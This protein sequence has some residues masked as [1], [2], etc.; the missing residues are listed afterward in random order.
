MNLWPLLAAALCTPAT[1]AQT[2]AP[3]LRSAPSAPVLGTG[4]LIAPL[5]TSSM[6]SAK[7]SPLPAAPYLRSLSRAPSLDLTP[8]A[9]A[10]APVPSA[11]SPTAAKVGEISAQTRDILDKTGDLSKASAAD[12]REAGESLDAVL[13]GE[14][15]ALTAAADSSGGLF[16]ALR[17]LADVRGTLE[18]LVSDLT[19]RQATIEEASFSVFNGRGRISGLALR[20]PAAPGA[21]PALRAYSLDFDVEVRS[22]LGGPVHFRSIEIAGLDLTVGESQRIEQ[23]TKAAARQS[24][25][26][27]ARIDRL[28]LRQ[29][30]LHLGGP[31]LKG[32]APTFYLR[33]MEWG[34]VTIGTDGK[35][36]VCGER[37]TGTP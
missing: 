37:C 18:R 9:V 27:G 21:E 36:T 33:D 29:A 13:R 3:R 8:S 32:T 25:G 24:P 23:A 11:W 34:P 22:L 10:A 2:L 35:I 15:K 31:W 30:R 16:G 7:A 20:D 19:G 5:G 28:V 1:A 26:K 6:F 17:S 4:A 12:A 14:D